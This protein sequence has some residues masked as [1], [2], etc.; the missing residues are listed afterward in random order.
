MGGR[1]S[2]S[3][4]AKGRG[5][6]AKGLGGQIQAKDE[7]EAMKERNKEKEEVIDY[8]HRQG[9]K[10][11]DSKTGQGEEWSDNAFMAARLIET[12][13]GAVLVKD[14]D[15]KEFRKAYIDAYDINDAARAMRNVENLIV[16]NTNGERP[17]HYDKEEWV[18]VKERAQ[19]AYKKL[20]DKGYDAE[21]IAAANAF[22][23]LVSRFNKTGTVPALVEK[24]GADL[25]KYTEDERKK[26]M[27]WGQKHY[28]YGFADSVKLLTGQ[29]TGGPGYK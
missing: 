22:H 19:S 13:R 21:Q 9:Q 28:G 1:G 25:N 12:D 7:L 8:L 10:A 14:P 15:F 6:S 24:K 3:S 26:I 23:T 18:A 11:A 5:V 29:R 2:K 4:G 16:T 17:L 27:I 20:Y